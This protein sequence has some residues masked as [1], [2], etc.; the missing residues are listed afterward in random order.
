[1]KLGDKTMKRKRSGKII[2]ICI[3][4]LVVLLLLPGK[5]LQATT[6][7]W[8][9]TG[10]VKDSSSRDG[11]EGARVQMR[12]RDPDTGSYVYEDMYSSNDGSWSFSFSAFSPSCSYIRLKIYTVP[13]GYTRDGAYSGSGGSI[14]GNYIY[15]S[16]APSGTYGDNYF[17]LK[18][19]PTPTPTPTSAGPTSTPAPTPT[20][21][22]IGP[23]STPRPTSTPPLPTPTPGGAPSC[24]VNDIPVDFCIT[25]AGGEETIT[26]S[27][28]AGKQFTGGYINML[29][30]CGTFHFTGRASVYIDGSLVGTYSTYKKDCTYH[31]VLGASL[32]IASHIAGKSSFQLKYDTN[33]RVDSIPSGCAPCYAKVRFCLYL[34]TGDIPTPTPTIEPWGECE[35]WATCSHVITDLPS[36]G[37]GVLA[38]YDRLVKRQNV[39]DGSIIFD[40]GFVRDASSVWW[41]MHDYESVSHYTA[42]VS[43]DGS[44]WTQVGSGEVF[45]SGQFCEEPCSYNYPNFGCPDPVPVPPECNCGHPFCWDSDT[46]YGWERRNGYL[47]A[48]SFEEHL[49]SFSERPIRYFKAT[50]SGA[51]VAILDA[52]LTTC[53]DNP[54]VSTHSLAGTLGCNEWYV[55]DVV[56]TISAIDDISAIDYIRYRVDSGSW[57]VV[58]SSSTSFTI[59]TDDSHT[60][61]YYAADEAGNVESPSNTA[62]IK[63]DQTDPVST[64]DLSGSYCNGWYNSNVTITLSATDATSGV[65]YIRYRLDGGSWTTYSSPFTVST[66]GERTLEYYAVDEACNVESV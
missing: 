57:Y 40:F 43:A 37:G 17:Y 35:A 2:T 10:Y 7:T 14:T 54:P 46:C 50:V 24:G 23:T 32:N 4:A 21:T 52:V 59:S 41:R 39:D 60:V 31:S 53:D 12:Y 18:V 20:A 66:E 47:C 64:H 48:I 63:I 1:M 62:T 6:Y 44:S 33:S 36:C 61:E 9:L 3:M 16:G 65:D 25:T 58:Y 28:P 27:A 11:I 49:A 26:I 45:T 56:V 55:S 29:Y 13:S 5:P 30:M 8:T 19:S 51:P 22:P 38:V 34:H 42:Y 15:F